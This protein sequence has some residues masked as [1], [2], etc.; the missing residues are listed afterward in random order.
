MRIAR[1]PVNLLALAVLGA[2]MIQS[3][4]RVQASPIPRHHSQTLQGIPMQGVRLLDVACP[5][6]SVCFA[7][8]ASAALSSTGAVVRTM[9]GGRHWVAQTIDGVTDLQ[10]VACPSRTVCYALG[11]DRRTKSVIVST[12]DGGMTWHSFAVGG[13]PDL[14][15]V[16]LLDLACPNPNTCYAVGPVFLP[17][18]RFPS[19]MVLGTT[20]GGVSWHLRS[21]TNDALASIVCLSTTA[22][23]AVGGRASG[24]EIHSVFLATGDGVST[25]DS[26]PADSLRGLYRFAC[27]SRRLCYDVGSRRTASGGR[28]GVVVITSTGGRTWTTGYTSGS[29]N[30]A[31]QGLSCPSTRVCVAAGDHGGILDTK[32]GG[33]T[34]TRRTVSSA[35]DLSAIACPDERVCYAVGWDTARSAATIIRTADRGATWNRFE[36][37]TV[38][39]PKRVGP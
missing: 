25:W 35:G 33:K 31:F 3:P 20:D 38:S 14:D 28:R 1:N 24:G 29:R 37:S 19:G 17:A 22:C 12:R 10:H 36:L 26:L 30:M 9:D 39:A 27:P 15:G 32:D 23:R 7:V 34:W 4:V 18:G 8:G 2:S 5:S 6:A 21:L 13:E 16:F 11:T